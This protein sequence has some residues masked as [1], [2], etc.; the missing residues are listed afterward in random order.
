MGSSLQYTNECFHQS[1]NITNA[2]TAGAT[3]EILSSSASDRRIYGMVAFNDNNSIQAMRV[4][5]T[6]DGVGYPAFTISA[7]LGAGTNG[8]LVAEDMFGDNNAASIMRK[9]TDANG[10]PYFNLPAGWS[11]GVQYYTALSGTTTIHVF[12]ETY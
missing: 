2:D 3:L 6:K 11:I 4:I 12:G 10:V 1:R 8:S 7:A 9:Q 5:L